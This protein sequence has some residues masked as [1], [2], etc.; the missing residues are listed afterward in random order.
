ML[1]CLDSIFQFILKTV[2]FPPYLTVVYDKLIAQVR[3]TVKN[4]Q[5]IYFK[6]ILEGSA[7]RLQTLM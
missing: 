3:V 1:C 2:W 4:E 7:K 6:P 5:L